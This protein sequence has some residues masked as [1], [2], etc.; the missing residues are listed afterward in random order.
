MN[1]AA[2]NIAVIV[3]TYSRIMDIEALIHLIKTRWSRYSYT[4]FVVHN[5][6]KDGHHATDA[7]KL[8]TEYVPVENNEGHIA[9]A[10]SLVKAGFRAARDF[11][12]FT[13]YLFIESDF[14]L[15]DDSLIE[16]Q[17]QNMADQSS[18][19]A[20]TIWVESR[21]SLAVDFFMVEADFMHAHPELLEWDGHPERYLGDL[22]S[23]SKVCVIEELRPTHVPSL[24]RKLHLPA[25]LADGGRFRIFTAAPA[26][27]HHIE[28]LDKDTVKGMAVKKGLANAVAGEILFDD[29]PT[30]ALPKELFWQKY[31]RYVP[32]S[33]WYKRLLKK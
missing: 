26:V 29:V 21:R 14:W 12:G 8:N 28:T 30:V 13:H 19:I 5:G 18:P 23:G 1:T 27:T 31:S 24:L 11:G 9:G 22:L 10:K 17:L 16:K 2:I 6:E 32:Q 20:T 15:L 25:S 3:R 33:W 7:I 4:I